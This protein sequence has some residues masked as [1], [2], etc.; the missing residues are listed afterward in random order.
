MIANVLLQ[1]K[2]RCMDLLHTRFGY[3]N[4]LRHVASGIGCGLLQRTEFVTFML[5]NAGDANSS[6]TILR[7]EG[8]LLRF[9]LGTKPRDEGQS[10][11]LASRDDLMVS[12]TT[13]LRMCKRMLIT[14][15]PGAINTMCHCRLRIQCLKLVTLN[16]FS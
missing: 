3:D 14:Q 11:D 15:M 12:T 6:I 16:E 7:V 2:Q 8:T 5:E 13:N 1:T 9:V 4:P 10:A